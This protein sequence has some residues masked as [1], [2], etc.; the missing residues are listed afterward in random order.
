M[1]SLERDKRPIEGVYFGDEVTEGWTVGRGGI[2]KI[3]CYGE[4]A[5]H[6]NTAWFAIYSGDN[7]R[8]RINGFKVTQITYFP[9]EA[10]P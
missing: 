9:E 5:L 1:D 4:P 8:W 3:E 2:T 10:K 6:S 7:L